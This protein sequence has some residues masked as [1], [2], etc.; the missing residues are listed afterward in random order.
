M[1]LLADKRICHLQICMLRWDPRRTFADIYAAGCCRHTKSNTCLLVY[2]SVLVVV[3][4]QGVLSVA[5][6]LDDMA[7][8]RG[9]GLL[10]TGKIL[11]FPRGPPE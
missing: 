10:R 8:L 5:A 7:L 6:I 2:T 9:I 3:E 1:I 11:H 4:E